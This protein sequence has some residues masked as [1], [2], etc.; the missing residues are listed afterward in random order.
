MGKKLY[1]NILI[2][3]I[4]YRTLYHANPLCI[5]FHEVDGHIKKY[6]SAKYLPLFSSDEKK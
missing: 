3:G 1:E 6:K 4:A 5:N 2:W